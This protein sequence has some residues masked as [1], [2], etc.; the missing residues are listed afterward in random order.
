MKKNKQHIS[1]IIYT[2]FIIQF[3][4]L[5][6]LFTCSAQTVS[7]EEP[8]LKSGKAIFKCKF[9]DY[10]P[11]KVG[12]FSIGFNNMVEVKTIPTSYNIDVNGYV[13]AEVD[14][15]AP[16]QVEIYSDF[17]GGCILLNPGEE[18]S[19]ELNMKDVATHRATLE[20]G[21]PES[22]DNFFLSGANAELNK[23]LFS[24]E[25][26]EFLFRD[27]S[28]ITDLI[29]GFLGMS[30]DDYKNFHV[31]SGVD[32]LARLDSLKAAMNLSDQL[33]EMTRLRIQYQVLDYLMQPDIYLNSA[34][35]IAQNDGVKTDYIVPKIGIEYFSFLK[36]YPVNSKLSLYAPEYESILQQCR[37]LFL[38]INE[39]EP[40]V[41]D[42]RSYIRHLEQTEIFTP[43]D[44]LVVSELKKQD[45][46]SWNKKQVND[47]KKS[48]I[49]NMQA[50]IDS[51]KLPV[52]QLQN[53]RKLIDNIKQV[54]EAQ[55]VNDIDA[56]L[57]D[58]YKG[59]VDNYIVTWAFIEDI[60]EKDAP[61]SINLQVDED[62]LTSFYER[63][64]EQRVRF[65]NN[66]L[67]TENDK[68]LSQ[69]LG[70]DKGFLFDILY[71]HRLL[72]QVDQGILADKNDAEK[73]SKMESFYWEYVTTRKKIEN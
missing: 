27:W 44:A 72:E 54:K 64:S 73:L 62:A 43:E 47:F 16:T 61:V 46:Q 7:L 20:E 5:F 45:Y 51:K 1:Q 26:A 29:K 31:Q 30:L 18:T 21:E 14:L 40:V 2:F 35:K 66:W 8:I 67:A 33:Y 6:N 37:Y 60:T 63:Y 28:T 24:D 70:T 9:N 12:F 50:I 49:K 36:D 19:L 56:S 4:F 17:I 32:K 52:E 42:E 23:Q 48:N 71:M 65:I 39:N 68:V 34:I 41:F 25:V 38:K 55:D 3:C 59:L 11:V 13:E 53:A 15:I 10:D 57:V 69:I 22:M 58:F